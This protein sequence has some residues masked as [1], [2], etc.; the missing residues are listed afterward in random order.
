MVSAAEGLVGLGATVARNA[1]AMLLEVSKGAVT[2]LSLLSQLER[3]ILWQLSAEEW[4]Q[5]AKRK[6]A[7]K[8]A[9]GAIACASCSCNNPHNKPTAHIDRLRICTISIVA[10]CLI[11]MPG[12]ET[13]SELALA[14]CIDCRH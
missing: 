11:A 6:E 3:I 1:P 7:A 5:S 8:P 9:G 12:P 10:A 2:T 13:A 4:K 14:C